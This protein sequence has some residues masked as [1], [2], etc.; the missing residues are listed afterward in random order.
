MGILHIRR[1]SNTLT[2]SILSAF[3]VFSSFSVKA[4]VVFSTPLHGKEFKM[5]NRIEWE[6]SFEADTKLFIVEKSEDGIEFYMEREIKAAGYSENEN[7]YRFLDIGNNNEKTF[8]NTFF[9]CI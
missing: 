3:F 9:S 2:L 8:N 1:L 5:G 7:G 4:D 6:T